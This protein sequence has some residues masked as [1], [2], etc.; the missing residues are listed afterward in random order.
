[1]NESNFLFE[2]NL[3]IDLSVWL[4]QNLLNLLIQSTLLILAGLLAARLLRRYGSAVQSAIYR[5]TL[6]AVMACPIASIVL[7]Q[8]NFDGWSI[9]LP[10][11][12]RTV[13]VQEEVQEPT[14]N[15]KAERKESQSTD[16]NENLANENLANENLA[17]A[18]LANE[19][20]QLEPRNVPPANSESYESSRPPL[21]VTESMD[22]NS[23]ASNELA[24]T[25]PPA[26]TIEPKLVARQLP[27]T[28]WVIAYACI[29]LI[30]LLGTCLFLARLIWSYRKLHSMRRQSPVASEQERLMCGELANR[31]RVRTPD[32][33]RNSLLSSPCLT[34][35]VSPSILMPSEITDPL[36]MEK[37]FAHELAHLRR[38]DTIWNLVQRIALALFFY[39]PLMWRLVYRLET[40]AEE[41]CDDYVVRHCQD[42]TGYAE[43]LVALA[44][45]NLL[46]PNIAGLGMFKSSR[47]MLGHRVVRIMDTTRKL[48]TQISI[49]TIIG[50]GMLTLAGSI[51]GGFLGNGETSQRNAAANNPSEEV[52][53]EGQVYSWKLVDVDGQPIVGATVRVEQISTLISGNQVEDDSPGIVLHS[54]EEG[55]IEM[56]ADKQMQTAYVFIVSEHTAIRYANL[57]LL[58]RD[59]YQALHEREWESD[60]YNHIAGDSIL[61]DPAMSVSGIVRDSE[62]G[63]PMPGVIVKCGKV[64]NHVPQAVTDENGAYRIGNLPLANQLWLRLHP[65]ENQPYLKRDFVNMVESR[66]EHKVDIELHRG[67]W[68]EGKVTDQETGQPVP[69]AYVYHF[70]RADNP[71]VADYP[72]YDGRFKSPLVN[73][74]YQTDAEGRY[75]MVGIPGPAVMGVAA[76]G[77]AL[78]IDAETE[79]ADREL[80]MTYNSNIEENLHRFADVDFSDP[81]AADGS[82]AASIDFQLVPGQSVDIKMIDPQGQP[83]GDVHVTQSGLPGT[84]W[85]GLGV[86]VNESEFSARN[87]SAGSNRILKFVS[88]D[89]KLGI[90]REIGIVDDQT[91]ETIQLQPFATVKCRLVDNNGDPVTGTTYFEFDSPRQSLPARLPSVDRAGNMN[92]GNDGV[93]GNFV[94]EEIVGGTSYALRFQRTE[95]TFPVFLN[96]DLAVEP[97]EVIDLGTINID[98]RVRPE[99][100]RSSALHAASDTEEETVLSGT[101]VDS[102]GQA[103]AGARVFLKDH[104]TMTRSDGA[105]QLTVPLLVANEE[106]MPPPRLTVAKDGFANQSYGIDLENPDDHR[107]ELKSEARPIHGRLVDPEG[108][109]IAGANIEA[110]LFSAPEN[111]DEYLTIAR[112]PETSLYELDSRDISRDVL[113]IPVFESVVSNDKGEFT[114]SGTPPN[115][116]VSLKILGPQIALTQPMVATTEIANSES[117]TITV[118]RHSGMAAESLGLV[119]I[120][121]YQPAIVCE[122]T[123]IIEG[124]VVDK[125]TGQPLENVEIYSDKFAGV[126]L[127]SDRSLNTVTDKSGRFRLTGMPVGHGN[128]ITAFPD[129][130]TPSA[131]PYLPRDLTVPAGTSLEPVEL[132]IEL[133]RGVWVEGQIVD[134]D[135]GKP[136]SGARA[137]YKPYNENESARENYPDEEIPQRRV[138]GTVET[139]SDGKFRLVALPGKGLLDVWM[140]KDNFYPPGQGWDD[141]ADEYK[142]ERGEILARGSFPSSREHPTAMTQI[143]VDEFN[144]IADLQIELDAGKSI[145][146]KMVDPDGQPLK[147]VFVQRAR[148]NIDNH[149]TSKESQFQALGFLEGQSRTLLFYHKDRK[150]GW[151]QTVRFDE[152][153]PVT[154]TLQP[155]SIVRG[156]LVDANGDP[157]VNARLRFDIKNRAGMFLQSLPFTAVTDENGDFEQIAMPGEFIVSVE[158]TNAFYSLYRSLEVPSG[159]TIE[160]GSLDVVAMTAQVQ[161]EIEEANLKSETDQEGE[162]SDSNDQASTERSKAPEATGDLS[163]T[164]DVLIQGIV[165]DLFDKPV[166]GARVTSFHKTECLSN[167]DG[168]F[169]ISVPR[170]KW[171]TASRGISLQVEKTGYGRSSTTVDT[172]N[173]NNVRMTLVNDDRPIEGQLVDTEGRPVVGATIKVEVLQDFGAGVLEKYLT[174]ASETGIVENLP[175]GERVP[176]KQKL[177]IKAGEKIRT[178]Q[179]VSVLSG[180]DGKFLIR[181]LGRGRLA[182]LKITGPGIAIRKALVA[183]TELG[184]HR[185]TEPEYNQ[186]QDGIVYDRQAVLICEPSQ[187]IEGVVVDRDT[188]K[189]LP[190][191]SVTS[192]GFLNDGRSS[193]VGMTDLKTTTDEQGRFA[194]DGMPKGKGNSIIVTAPTQGEYAQPYITQVIDLPDAPG[195]EPVTIEAGIQKGIWITGQVTNKESGEPVAEACIQYMPF[196]DNEFATELDR[197]HQQLMNDYYGSRTDDQGRYRFVAIPGPAALGVWVVRDSTYP[198]GQGWDQVPESRKDGQSFKPGLFQRIDNRVCAV[199]VIDPNN[200]G[201]QKDFQLT[202]GKTLRFKMVDAEGESLSGCH[203]RFV[204]TLVVFGNQQVHDAEFE[205]DGFIPGKPRLVFFKHT[206]KQLAALVRVDATDPEMVTVTLRKKG[207]MKATLVNEKGDPVEGVKISINRVSE[208]GA[209]L[210][211]T[212]PFDGD[213]GSDQA[214]VFSRALYPGNYMGYIQTHG[215]YAVVPKFEVKPGETLDLGSIDITKKT[216]GFRMAPTPTPQND[217]KDDEATDR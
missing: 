79:A 45:S 88:Q 171:A 38:H 126:E 148:S 49:P 199:A 189:P 111:M 198:V 144:D 21:T 9:Q 110:Y 208:N 186:L 212:V 119:E 22:S 145:T 54:D 174:S 139:E 77:Y 29:G 35:I 131:L 149:Y 118:Y 122:P 107:L 15:F 162:E 136:L 113:T 82:S 101:V 42:R 181:D 117:E 76:G 190:G 71:H 143:D 202:K 203:A 164:D 27:N 36:P 188:G 69:D 33:R 217:K 19:S 10:A 130:D 94:Y 11:S 52:E 169:S 103:V 154:V 48:T 155:N 215:N 207:S 178:A 2:S 138:N 201:L 5:A 99:P 95:A 200:D 12:T 6:V 60:D 90:V 20:P 91:T 121:G 26:I 167:T 17:I 51:L 89:R 106:V 168:S 25:V 39:Q 41:V 4:S 129:I 23:N 57:I 40:T 59:R 135:T 67:I 172:N 163:E 14:S 137:S 152:V 192:Y 128:E 104:E 170:E 193:M 34:G 182:T 179:E 102:E 180:D 115:V 97:G 64:F 183:T 173:A 124:I 55:R 65:N 150:L 72:E 70:P 161:K 56:D 159:K 205:L 120:H 151:I 114:I 61:C 98:S 108:L 165:V 195:I 66:E 141:I 84:N 86:L 73:K 93:D 166:P 132:R 204:P 140:V 209:L 83:I 58:D 177:E 211:G 37:A 157:V 32:V 133:T 47:S 44:E 30:W 16:V 46:A 194:L 206:E 63:Q 1:M 7:Q 8:L 62:T 105:F 125:A 109:P 213:S 53:Q 184:D 156:K 78:G 191:F 112:R 185:I 214:G 100:I 146:V 123:Q 96:S 31:F 176:V 160:L 74:H 80:A 81:T 87:F 134:R 127:S 28:V 50:I 3:F 75:R 196:T 197:Q 147:D 43:Q 24:T 175:R 142:N 13:M 158:S 116:V 85:M 68:I 153:S 216:G 92:F 210:P 18:G 187:P